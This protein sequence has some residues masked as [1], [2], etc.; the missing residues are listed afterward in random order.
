MCPP[1]L[2][3]SPLALPLDPAALPHAQWPPTDVS[4]APGSVC[5]CVLCVLCVLC[6]CVCV[7]V[8]GG[9]GGGGGGGWHVC[10]CMRIG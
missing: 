6:V 4:A 3:A 2:S 1:P 10:I 8:C 5:V 7:C 9:G